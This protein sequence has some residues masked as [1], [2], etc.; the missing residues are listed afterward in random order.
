MDGPETGLVRWSPNASIDSF[1][2][3][4]LHHRVVQLYKPTGYAKTGLFEYQNVSRHEDFPTLTSFDW[5]PTVSGVVAIGTPTGVVNLLKIDD[6]SNAYVELNLKMSRTCQAVAFSTSNLLAVGLDR[7]RSDRSLYI[8][9]VNRLSSSA[10]PVD[11]ASIGSGATASAGGFPKDMEPFGEPIEVR[12][13]SVS[14]SSVRFFE[15][16]PS[17]LVVGIKGQG[18]RIHDLRD[19]GLHPLQFQTRCTNNLAIDYADPNYVASSA[20]DH[21]GIMVW[22]KRATSRSMASPLYLDA[23]DVDELP[24]GGALR[25]DRAVTPESEQAINE[26]KASVIRALRYCR[27]HR[28]MLGVLS[29]SGQLK[30][31]E[32][33]HEY[34]PPELIA[35]HSPELLEVRRSNEMDNQY[36]D[37]RHKNERIVSFDWVTI[38]S[39]A[40]RPRVLVLRANGSYDILEKPSFTTTYPFKLIPWTA[41]YRGLEEGASYHAMMQF[42]TNQAT[43]VLYPVA[44]EEALADIPIFA[45]DATEINGAIQKAQKE[46]AAQIDADA[47]AQAKTSRLSPE[48]YSAKTVAKKLKILRAFEKKHL[49]QPPKKGAAQDARAG[50]APAAPTATAAATAASTAGSLADLTDS[51]ASLASV[52]GRPLTSQEL[53]E[54]L[55]SSTL[56]RQGFP[57]EAQAVLD[58]VMLLRAKERYLFHCARNQ[59]IVA[60]DPWLRDVWGWLGD[61]EAAAD[62]GDMTA[63]YLDLSYMGVAGIWFEDLGTNK[64]ARIYGIDPSSSPSFPDA[65]NW[66]RTISSIC[67]KRGVRRYE[68]VET[69]KPHHRQLCLEICGWG[70]PPASSLAANHSGSDGAD[71][72]GETDTAT[73]RTTSYHTMAAA[74]ALFRGDNRQ[75]VQILKMASTEH[76]ELLFVSLALQLMGRRDEEGIKNGA[77]G[78]GTVLGARGDRDQLD[79]DEALASKTDPYL[80]AISSLIATG[81]WTTIAHQ[82]SLPLRERVFVAVRMFDDDQLSAWLR[83]TLAEAVRTGD[84]EGLVLTGLTE[85]AVDIWA[86]YVDKFH[87]VQTATLVMSMAAPRF[88]DDYRCTAWRTAYRA[89][90]QRHRAFFQRAKFEVESTKRSKGA[91]DGRPKVAPPARQIALRCVYCDAQTR[92]AVPPPASGVGVGASASA[93]ASASGSGVLGSV[94]ALDNH[95]QLPAKLAM[96]GVS[97]PNCKRHLPRCVVCLE[98]VGTPRSDRPEA[99]ADADTRLAARFPTFCLKCDHVLHLDHARQWFSR[100][101]ECPVPECRC[102]CNFRANPELNYQ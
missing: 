99:S 46:R 90:L 63:H 14:V 102:R 56:A 74:Q 17:T 81:D 18:L 53:H 62:G 39:P 82:T 22:D 69:R 16:N 48:F 55:L 95:N 41:P 96:A 75:A 34:C 11:A 78:G 59:E 3:V 71:G 2:H 52:S 79:F 98:I 26:S 70:R 15:D 38:G 20:L 6:D 72:S 66:Q 80:R 86:R 51:T 40:L 77:A 61:A 37:P 10:R 44:F 1:L 57:S 87:D 76:P 94:V 30:V 88:V 36:S 73:E 5:S 19:P 92:L 24:W 13:A 42:E 83:D 84:V 33:K 35:D 21:P 28:G 49:R 27:D 101:A 32:T 65:S 93:S 12:E 50:T 23:V 31:Y 43:E 64:D 9:D 85:P 29:G 25:L 54:S 89:Y 47:L 4:N 68:G 91:A 58:H 100:H 45:S 7:V 8:W 67:R 60:D 97:C